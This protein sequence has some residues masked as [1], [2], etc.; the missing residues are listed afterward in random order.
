MSTP[1]L[2]V[3]DNAPNFTLPAQGGREV[4]LHALRPQRIVLYFYPKDD[5]P[6]CTLE[7]QDFTSL[8]DSFAAAG[9]A[10]FGIS[11]DSVKSHDAFC[12][13]HNLSVTLLSDES[14][15]VCDDYGV[16]LEK[17]NYGRTYMGI[18]RTTFLID[19]QG[20]ISHVWNKVRAKGHAQKVLETVQAM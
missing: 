3:G 18:E 17:R 13:K 9:G 1:K 15:Q 11:K 4:T 2:K 12:A 19:A 10:V 20:V 16:W 6:G 14:G 8:S 7:A 5:T